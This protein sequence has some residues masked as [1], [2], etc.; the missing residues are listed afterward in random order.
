MN[1][2][3]IFATIVAALALLAV[4]QYEQQP[5]TKY[6]FADFKQEFGKVYL[7]EA[8]EQFRKTVFLRNYVRIHERNADPSNSWKMGLTQFADLTE[9]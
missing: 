8:E 9:A 5:S 2:T 6:S 7:G 3:L 1:K 4:R